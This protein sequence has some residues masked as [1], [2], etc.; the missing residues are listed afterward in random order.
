MDF[1]L[2]SERIMGM[3]ESS[4]IEDGSNKFTSNGD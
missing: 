4:G 3:V 1:N 2:A